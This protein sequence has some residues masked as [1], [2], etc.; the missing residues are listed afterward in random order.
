M[1]SARSVLDQQKREDI[2]A[3]MKGITDEEIARMSNPPEGAVKVRSETIMPPSKG[4]KDC[5]G[6]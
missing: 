6:D 2:R 5:G 1:K 3:I 4:N